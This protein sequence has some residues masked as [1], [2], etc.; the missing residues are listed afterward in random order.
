MGDAGGVCA[1]QGLA[2]CRA[3]A[4]AGR[5]E[6][7][8]ACN[9]ASKDLLETIAHALGASGLAPEYLEVEITESAVMQNASE[10]I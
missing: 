10:A 5:G 4:H 7:L 8:R 1:E 2:G 3:A 9:S 6:H